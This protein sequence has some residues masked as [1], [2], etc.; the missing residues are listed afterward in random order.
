V[1]DA[2]SIH[3]DGGFLRVDLAA[4]GQPDDQL[5]IQNQG[6]GVNQIS[7]SGNQ[8]AIGVPG[9][10]TLVFGTFAGGTA[11]EPL[12]VMFNENASPAHVSRLLRSITFRNLSDNPTAEHRLVRFAIH[13]GTELLSDAALREIEVMPINDAP[14]L[15]TSPGAT[16][17]ED[18]EPAKIIDSLLLVLDNDSE[19]FD[20]G[21]LTIAIVENEQSSDRLSVIPQGDG[22]DEINV[23]GNQI[24]FAGV[25]IASFTGGFTTSDPLV[26][27]LNEN[28]TVAAVQQL[29]RRVAFANVSETPSDLTR[30]VQFIVTDG[31]GGTSHGANKDIIMV[32]N[33]DISLSITPLNA[34]QSEGH[35]GTKAFTFV[36]SR[37]GYTGVATTVD[38][39]IAGDVDAADFGG[40]LPSGT[41][42]FPV[43]S[44]S[45][46]ITLF[47]SGDEQAEFDE[48]FTVTLGNASGTAAIDVASADGVIGNDDAAQV[49]SVVVAEP[50]S[51]QRSF[52]DQLVITFEG[53]VGFDAGAFSV[54]QLG[55]S[56]GNVTVVA[57]DPLFANGQ[58][59]VVLTF[60]GGFT[61]GN[62][63]ALVDGNYRLTIDASKVRS[64]TIDLD[65]D[66]DGTA[67][68]SFVF[69]EEETDN[70]FAFY[71][72]LDGNRRV[73]LAEFN[74][75]RST[76]GKPSSD[77]GYNPWLDYQGLGTIGLADFN[78]FRSRFGR[79]LDY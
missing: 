15:I 56:G 3:F 48:A 51:P 60:A 70:F 47:V 13:D 35:S 41:V 34:V 57:G 30:V 1:T 66:G 36:V 50:A 40:A 21:T 61:R 8:V 22:S 20:A 26:F 5:S 4:G 37:S 33:T 72:D 24:L 69:G 32:G 59:T 63:N 25:A 43:G 78:Q 46:V 28:A 14:V 38:Y 6:V 27:S 39:Q 73:E 75:F 9:G 49:A 44:T 53:R 10:S 16:S 55:P 45:Q 65:G 62:F 7:V 31:D 12:V 71:G 23:V 79:R 18:N 42:T 76:F 77:P 68:G 52:V 11:G 58:T 54:E 67:G 19:N 2:D 17:Y 29:A 74:A 64:G